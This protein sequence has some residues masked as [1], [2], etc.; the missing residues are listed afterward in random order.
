MSRVSAAIAVV[1]RGIPVSP[2]SGS[3]QEGTS[4]K[5]NMTFITRSDMW[6]TCVYV[7]SVN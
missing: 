6:D 1:P 3:G 4:R 7:L 5:T 2:G